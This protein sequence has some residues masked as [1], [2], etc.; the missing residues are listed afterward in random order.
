MT[1]APWSE[2]S[3][4]FWTTAGTLLTAAATLGLVVGAFLAWRTARKTLLQMERDSKAQARPYLHAELSPSIAGSPAWDLVIRNTGRSSARN[5]RGT[6]DGYPEGPFDLVI[7]E[8]RRELEEG[9]TIAPTS[10]LRMFWFMGDRQKG[11]TTPDSSTGY[12]DPRTLSLTYS[13]DQGAT[14][15]DSFQLAPVP[16]AP[17]PSKGPISPRAQGVEKRMSDIVQAI[18]S[19]RLE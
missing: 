12:A 2:Y 6:L 8:V 9:R 15:S 4:T 7:C 17:A 16:I 19:L 11:V 3:M 10:A 13:D 18:G 1:I 14:F 5:V